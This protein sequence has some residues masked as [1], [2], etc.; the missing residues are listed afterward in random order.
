LSRYVAT[1]GSIFSSRKKRHVAISGC[2]RI[3]AAR[4]LDRFPELLY[5]LLSLGLDAGHLPGVVMAVRERVVHFGHVEVVPV[6]NGFGVD[7]ALL[8]E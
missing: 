7:T 8:N 1:F 6:G 3:Y 5:F 4:A 2:I